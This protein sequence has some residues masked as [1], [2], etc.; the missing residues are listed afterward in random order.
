MNSSRVA[1]T[2][3]LLA[4]LPACSA[5]TGTDE[6]VGEARQAL[7]NVCPS[8]SVA[9]IDIASFQH[10]SGA[11]INWG[12]VAGAEKFVIIKATESN[13][14]VNGYYAGDI[15]GARGAGLIAGSYHFLAPSSQ[16]GVSGTAQAQYFLAH[17]SIQQGD[18]P[19]MLDV[20]TSS[21][22]N[23]VLP[24]VADVTSWLS[25]VESATGVKPIIYIGYYV[26]GDLGTPGALGAYPINVPNYSSCPSYPDSYPIAN[27]VMWQKTSTAS[28]PG[29]TG[30]VDADEFY[31]DDNALLNFV[32]ADQAATGYLDHAGCDTVNGWGWDP[33]NK[34]ASTNVDVYYNGPAGDAG[35]TGVRNAANVSRQDL[36]T[37]LGSCDHAFSMRTPRS[38]FDGKPHDVHAYAID[39]NGTENGELNESPKTIGCAPLTLPKNTVKRW[40]TDPDVFGAWKFDAF[41]DVAH[42]DQHEIDHEPDGPK[43]SAGPV[44]VQ[45]DDGTPEV[46]VIDRG[47][48]RHVINPDALAA[49]RFAVA[50]TPAAMVYANPKGADWP[51]TPDLVQGTAANVYMLDV[52]TEHHHGG[53][54]G[55]GSNEG[56]AG[57]SSGSGSHQPSGAGGSDVGGG[58]GD[59]D[60]NSGCNVADRGRSGDDGWLS[61]VGL[62]FALAFA[63]RR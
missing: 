24:S 23:S 41:E 52:D 10:P 11:G 26:I 49:W 16:T 61:I 2:A 13:D 12:Q 29:I 50:K 37:A 60:Q 7:S 55:G 62:A 38:L 59:V 43:I 17:A 9:G 51:A 20:E 45:A 39:L 63:R 32:H 3:L 4:A 53:G 57:P 21:L 28:I 56:G 35:A 46:W 58:A 54:S 27:L 33:D 14:Y 36:C 19:P 6:D 40:I 1:A 47:E 48:R 25:T 8:A 22:Y 34:T 18:L 15:A 42:V 5:L 31:G 30:N 44:C